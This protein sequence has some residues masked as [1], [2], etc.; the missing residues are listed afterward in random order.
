MGNVGCRGQRDDGA[1]MGAWSAGA[2]RTVRM[3][4]S[5]V[6]GAQPTVLPPIV[7][8]LRSIATVRDAG[9][10]YVDKTRDIAELLI[11]L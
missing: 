5:Q 9:S 4:S 6:A 7:P 2:A 8:E 11:S 1:L 10:V 3:Y